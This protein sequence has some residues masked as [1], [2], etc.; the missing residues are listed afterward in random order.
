MNRIIFR[1]IRESETDQ[2]AEIE[3]ICFSNEEACTYEM[4]QDRMQYAKEMFL[5]AED[6]ESGKIAGYITGVATKEEKFCDQ[7]FFR[8]SLH[9]PSGKNVMIL[10][11]EVLPA[12]RMQ[13]IA[14]ELVKTY[15]QRQKEQGREKMI[16]TCKSALVKMYEKMGFADMG[17][18]ASVWGNTHWH[19]MVCDLTRE[20]L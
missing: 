18:S 6:A 19:E 12:Y 3:R 5:V 13:G 16:L 1:N 10:G 7:F 17:I 14:K 9:D 11:L 8:G 20:G 15:A 4:V 2:A